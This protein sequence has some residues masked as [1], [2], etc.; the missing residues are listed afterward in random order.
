MSSKHAFATAALLVAAMG[1]AS[2]AAA[3]STASAS[4]N[5]VNYQLI[6]LN[7]YDGIAP[8]ITFGGL[9]AAANVVLYGDT[10]YS[11]PVLSDGSLTYGPISISNASGSAF[12][13]IQEAS[14]ASRVEIFSNSGFGASLTEFS[15]VLS[16]NT[17]LIFT[18]DASVSA[19]TDPAGGNASATAYLQVGFS[20]EGG[21]TDVFNRSTLLS[22]DGDRSGH[23]LALIDSGAMAMNGTYAFAT[24]S[25]AS[26]LAAPIPEPASVG[27]LLAGLGVLA[28]LQ[29]RR[30]SRT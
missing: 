14:G 10:G 24:D 7:P 30:A 29:R 16:P 21:T 26:S 28:G 4:I 27:M 12:A 15:F 17:R 22:T 9:P 3:Q 23:L 18:G 13:E 8:S 20:N 2:T 25:E 19:V 6:D 11:I 1:A 5:N